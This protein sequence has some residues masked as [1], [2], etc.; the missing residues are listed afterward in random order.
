MLSGRSAF[1]QQDVNFPGQLALN[2]LCAII[3]FL[4]Q[5]YTPV[6][7]QDD[8]RRQPALAGIFGSFSA[9]NAARQN[10]AGFP[11]EV[12]RTLGGSS[13][14]NSLHSFREVGADVK[15]RSRHS[16]L[17]FMNSTVDVTSPFKLE[18]LQ[19]RINDS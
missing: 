10:I 3:S 12:F 2:R 7:V 15:T 13:L 17:E 5:T 11:N 16:A 19:Q 1:V 14:L 18:W 9:V 8:V 6:F 4:D